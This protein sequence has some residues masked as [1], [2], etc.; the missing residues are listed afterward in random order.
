MS[1]VDALQAALAGEHA[2]VYG[3]GLVGAHTG[4]PDLARSAYELHR[5]RRAPLGHL[6][7]LRDGEPVAALPA[8]ETPFTV[9]GSS[10]A[11]ELAT[12]LERR[13]A[14]IYLDL[15]GITTLPGLRSFAATA[16]IESAEL[17]ARWSGETTAL[18]GIDPI[19]DPAE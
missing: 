5:A 7:R 12:L 3:Y 8:Y 4:N 1:A 16:L 10:S 18:P 14:A 11:R 19:P 9:D 17:A 15:V 6:I 13:L 2:S